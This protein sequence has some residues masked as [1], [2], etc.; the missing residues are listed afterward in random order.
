MNVEFLP[1]L[2]RASTYSFDGESQHLLHVGR[3]LGHQRFVA[4]I[5]TQMSQQ[6]GVERHRLPDGLPRDRRNVDAGLAPQRLL[7]ILALVLGNLRM[8]DRILVT[9]QQ[10]G[11]RPDRSD[12]TKHVEDRWPTT[13]PTVISKQTGQR[14]RNNR[15]KLGT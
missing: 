3:Q 6:D 11:N 15:S 8:R 10:E 2:M 13:V 5:L 12:D 7:D 1:R 4:V 14:H 9:G